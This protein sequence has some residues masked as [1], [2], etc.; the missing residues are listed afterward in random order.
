MSVMKVDK[1][2]WATNFLTCSGSISLEKVISDCTCLLC[3][4][5]F[6]A[7]LCHSICGG[8]V[9]IFAVSVLI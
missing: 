9:T 2:V 3:L 6:T 8:L 5:R 1:S 4:G 7:G